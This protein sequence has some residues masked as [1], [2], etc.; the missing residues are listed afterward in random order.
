MKEDSYTCL[1]IYYLAKHEISGEK[2]VMLT[3]ANHVDLCYYREIL[4]H[5]IGRF[6]LAL[7]PKHHSLKKNCQRLMKRDLDLQDVLCTYHNQSG[8]K[9]HKC[10]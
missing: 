10:Y 4:L 6:Y 8:P 2:A 7:V 5:E 9:I 3:Q 1:A